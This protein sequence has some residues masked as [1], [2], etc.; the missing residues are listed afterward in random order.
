MNKLNPMIKKFLLVS[1]LLFFVNIINAQKLTQF[2]TDSV[3]FIKELNEFFIDN[4]ANKKVAEEYMVT[5]GKFWKSPDFET[6]YKNSFGPK[7]KV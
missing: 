2:S 3:K 4:S 5:F 1:F 7:K 6:K